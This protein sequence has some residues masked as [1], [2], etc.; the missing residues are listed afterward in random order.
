MLVQKLCRQLPYDQ[1]AAIYDVLHACPYPHDDL[2]MVTFVLMAMLM[3]VDSAV[4]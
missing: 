1:C 2:D 4:S 3:T